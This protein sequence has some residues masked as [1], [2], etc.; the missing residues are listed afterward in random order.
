MYQVSIAV[1][2]LFHKIKCPKSGGKDVGMHIQ[3]K[4]ILTIY[5]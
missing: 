5:V 2:K 1:R 4:E 3:K